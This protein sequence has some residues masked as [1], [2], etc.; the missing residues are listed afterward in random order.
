MRHHLESIF[1]LTT[2]FPI[3]LSAHRVLHQNQY[4]SF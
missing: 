3:S 1:L 2:E 4:F